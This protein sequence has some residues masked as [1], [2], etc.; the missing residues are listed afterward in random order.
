MR[1]GPLAVMSA[2]AIALVGPGLANAKE[3]KV[4]DPPEAHDMRLAGYNDLQARS[5]YQPTIHQQNGRWI[6]GSGIPEL[7]R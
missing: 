1:S 7:R 4:G 6:A 5:A 2:L 3:Q